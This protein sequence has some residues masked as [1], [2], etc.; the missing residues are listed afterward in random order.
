MYPNKQN[1][2]SE[3]NSHSRSRPKQSGVSGRNI[4]LTQHNLAGGILQPQ[5]FLELTPF[6]G[7]SQD[8]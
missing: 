4:S 3:I 8:R 2:F 6:E 5:N 7:S 1:S